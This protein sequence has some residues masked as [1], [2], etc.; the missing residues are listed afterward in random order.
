[1]TREHHI[2]KYLRARRRIEQKLADID[3]K[4]DHIIHRLREDDPRTPKQE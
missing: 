2:E 4:L 1:M 3:R